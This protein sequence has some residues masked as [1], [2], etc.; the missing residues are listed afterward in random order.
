[1][2]QGDRQANTSEARNVGTAIIGA[3]MSGLVMGIRLKNAGRPFRILEKAQSVGGTWR[4]NTYPGLACD[5]PS[6]FYALSFEPNPDW[7][8]RFSP[9]REICEYFEGVA[10]KYRLHDDIDFGIEITDARFE[11]G[12]WTIQAGNGEVIRADFL[13]D[14]TGPLHIKNYP[15]IEGLDDFEG[16]M[17]HSAAWDH[18]APLEGKRIGVIGN[19][20]TGVQMMAPLSK[21]ASELTMFQRTAQWVYPI[22]NRTYTE[23]ERKWTRRLPVL[24][25][26]TRFVYRQL[27]NRASAGVVEDGFWRKQMAK[28]CREHLETVKDPELREKLRPDYEPGCKR[29]VMSTDFYPTLEKEHVHLETGGI[30]HI[31][32]GGVVTEDGKLHELDVLVLATGFSAHEWGI[33][34]VVGLNGIGQKEAWAEGPRTYRSVTMPGFPNF[35]MIVGP[36]SPI[37]NISIIEVS[38]TQTRYI[39][40]CIER[41][42]QSPG[43]AIMPRREAAERFQAK[44]GEAMKD[45]IWVTGC[46]SWYVGPDGAPTLWPWTAPEFHRQMKKP[47]F[48][49]FEFIDAV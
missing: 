31:E 15:Q 32:A 33:A 6:F 28:G 11:D 8:H 36:N 46:S 14:A 4:E 10:K 1:M 21:V 38:E 18:S 24:G 25:A 47:D 9:G 35:F 40:D 30:D 5:V 22:G 16:T 19:G 41:L 34:N 26:L 2:G 45:T 23:R 37:G 44:L 3:G 42:D 39:L 13:I 17:F 48:V 20:S 7:S 49:D 43:K 29:L 12:G 27:F